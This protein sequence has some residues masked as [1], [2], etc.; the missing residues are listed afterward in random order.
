[1]LLRLH[2]N[3]DADGWNSSSDEN[4]S[5]DNSSMSDGMIVI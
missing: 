1:M 4:P 2:A 3:V 5:S